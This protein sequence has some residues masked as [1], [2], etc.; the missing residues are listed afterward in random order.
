MNTFRLWLL[1]TFVCR[2]IDKTPIVIGIEKTDILV[3]SLNASLSTEAHNRLRESLRAAMGENAPRVLI[4]EEG[5]RIDKILRPM[6]VTH[7]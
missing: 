2:A 3:V 4:F 1:R 6:A 7:T 5:L